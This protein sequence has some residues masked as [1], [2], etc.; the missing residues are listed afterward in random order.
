MEHNLLKLIRLD[1]VNDRG[2]K[3]Q[4]EFNYVFSEMQVGIPILCNIVSFSLQYK[5]LRKIY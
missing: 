2:G 1:M 3:F 4:F 5:V